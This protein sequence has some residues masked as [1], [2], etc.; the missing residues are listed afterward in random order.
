MAAAGEAHITCLG[1]KTFAADAV[2]A[3]LDT[4][5]GA[6]V[7]TIRFFETDGIPASALSHHPSLRQLDFSNCAVP[8]QCDL[9]GY[10]QLHGLRELTFYIEDESHVPD[11]PYQLQHLQPLSQLEV[12]DIEELHTEGADATLAALQRLQELGLSGGDLHM[13]PASMA[14]LTRLARLDLS[15]TRVSG[16]WQH[17][18]LQLEHLY[19]RNIGLTTVPPELSRLSHLTELDLSG[20]RQLVGGSLQVLAR[21]GSLLKLDMVRCGL[22]NAGLV[23]ELPTTLDTLGLLW[24]ELTAVPAALAPLTGLTGLNLIYN[25]LA[26]GWQHLSGMQQLASLS[27]DHCCLS[28]VPLVLSQLTALTWLGMRSNPIASGWQHLSLLPLRYVLTDDPAHAIR[29]FCSV[30]FWCLNL[31]EQQLPVHRR[32]R[33]LR[34]PGA[35]R[36][37]RGPAGATAVRCARVADAI[38]LCRHS[39]RRRLS[40]VVS[41]NL[42]CCA[43]ASWAA[44]SAG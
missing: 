13:V 16:G 43:A 27:V 22:D 9:A 19:L 24:N 1:G 5:R 10:T 17:L 33:R 23:V 38:R 18:P 40:C 11:T 2:C 32:I 4:L 25:K 35:A 44:L 41:L 3:A 31:C 14:S 28:A 34:R 20:N 29:R 37:P 30:P 36:H 21:L 39:S 15:D 26:G 12:L 8:P 7:V 42:P 6:R